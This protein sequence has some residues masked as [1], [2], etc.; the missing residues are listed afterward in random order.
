MRILVFVA[1]LVAMALTAPSHAFAQGRWT[2]I[3]SPGF[4][5][6]TAGSEQRAEGV[7]RDLEAFDGLLRRFTNAPAER[8]PTKLEVYLLSSDQFAET[9]PDIGRSIVG[10]YSARVDQIAAFAIFSSNGLSG[11]DTLYHEYA[12]HFM[13]QHFAN[14]YP[15]WYVEGFAEFMSTAVMGSE[16]IELGRGSEGRAYALRNEQWMPIERL[17]SVAPRELSGDERNLFYAQSWLLTHYLVLTPGKMAQFQAYVRALRLGQS[18]T[19]ALQ[20]G[21]GV[22]PQEMLAELRRYFRGNPNALALNRPAQVDRERMRLSRLPASADTLLPLYARLRYGVREADGPAVLERVRQFAGGGGDR[23]ALLTLA[24]AE[25]RLGE[26]ARARALLG[27]HL[28]ANPE[29]VEALYLMGSTYLRD[30]D[31]A[32]AD[33]SA[34]LRVQARRYFGRAYQR[35]PNHVPSLYRYAESYQGVRMDQPTADNYLNVLL[36]ANQLAPQIDQIGINAA[37]ALMAR[38]RHAEAIPMLRAIAYDPHGGS[39]ARVAREMLAEA[40]AGLRAAA[41]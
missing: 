5:V 16:R 11:Q 19:A 30:A 25:T 41:N 28:D 32:A 1:W 38:G 31:D 15:A 4:I 12:H 22:T 6:Y 23:F 40:E 26:T 29:D 9:L 18:P 39:N 3:E 13:F 7:A 24:L 35:D 17:I 34:A 10:L 27:P 36:L 14:A 33:Q 20:A 8:S 37:S 2:R 21:F